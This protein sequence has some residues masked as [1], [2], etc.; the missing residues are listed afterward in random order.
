MGLKD[1]LKAGKPLKVK[2]AEALLMEL[3][4]TLGHIK[5]SHH[6]WVRDQEIFT[7]PVHGK[8]LKRWVTREL[9]KLYYGQ[10]K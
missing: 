3:G 2:E 1:K 7:V 5:G 6:H 9:R 8:E 4:F 10:K